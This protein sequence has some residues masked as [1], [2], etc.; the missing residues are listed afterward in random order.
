[1]APVY[2]RYSVVPEVPSALTI[3]NIAFQ[4]IF[5]PDQLDRLREDVDTVRSHPLVG[6]YA[7]VGGFLYDVDTGLVSHEC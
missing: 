7:T 4:G 5:G 6:P 1:M 3:H 2:M